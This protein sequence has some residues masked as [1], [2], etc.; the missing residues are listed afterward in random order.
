MHMLPTASWQRFEYL[1]CGND[2][3]WHATVQSNGL[4]PQQSSAAGHMFPS[5]PYFLMKTFL[6]ATSQPA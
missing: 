5:E 4:T 6:A 2:E 3:V 1:L